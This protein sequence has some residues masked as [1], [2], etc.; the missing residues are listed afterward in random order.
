MLKSYNIAVLG[1]KNS[2]KTSFVKN[3]ENVVFTNKRPTSIHL[4]IFQS[5]VYYLHHHKTQ[6]LF[7]FHDFDDDTFFNVFKNVG[8]FYKY[9]CMLVFYSPDTSKSD[10]DL[11]RINFSHKYGMYL[12]PTIHLL[13]KHE[14]YD[15]KVNVHVNPHHANLLTVNSLSPNFTI[16]KVVSELLT[17]LH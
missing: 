14:L 1:A 13:N 6:S 9:N 3:V 17:V 4:N 12:L 5:T 16:E 7:A 10:S 11:S 15:L 8:G 2:G